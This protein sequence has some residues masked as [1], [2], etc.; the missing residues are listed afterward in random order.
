LLLE[1]REKHPQK[2]EFEIQAQF[3]KAKE[4]RWNAIQLDKEITEM[5]EK[6]EALKAESKKLKK[7]GD[8]LIIHSYL[9]KALNQKNYTPI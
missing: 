1:L 2:T 6:L 8:K 7:D 9:E 4:L 5:K 3:D